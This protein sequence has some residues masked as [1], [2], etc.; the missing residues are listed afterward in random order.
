MENEDL[1]VSHGDDLLLLFNAT[2]FGLATDPSAKELDTLVSDQMVEYWTNFAKYHDPSPF[3]SKDLPFWNALASSPAN[4]SSYLEIGE[5]TTMRT[6][7]HSESMDFLQ[8][9]F[10]KNEINVEVARKNEF[11]LFKQFAF[12]LNG[13]Q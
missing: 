12:F 3:Q 2:V 5:N 9:M 7:F 6:G 10:W 11:D 4:Q 8:D 1:G 13:K